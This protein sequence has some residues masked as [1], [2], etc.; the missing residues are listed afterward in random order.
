[1]TRPLKAGSELSCNSQLAVASN[2]IMAAPSGNSTASSM[3][4]VGASAA[5]ISS[6]PKAMPAKASNRWLG[7]ARLADTSAPTNAPA[8]MKDI[9]R[10]NVLAPELKD[11][12]EP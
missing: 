3:S 12:N 9:S 10:P 7:L 2:V 4:S 1:M 11:R 8:P 6:A 5:P